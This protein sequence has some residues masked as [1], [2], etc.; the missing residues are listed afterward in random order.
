[1][2]AGPRCRVAY[3]ELMGRMEK[4]MAAVLVPEGRFVNFDKHTVYVGRNDGKE[5]F[6]ILVFSQGDTNAPEQ[7]VKAPRGRIEVVNDQIILHLYDMRAL[8]R[9][10]NGTW[11]VGMAE[12]CPEVL[13]APPKASENGKLPL[14]DMTFGQLRA[15]LRR[16]EDRFNE[17]NSSDRTPDELRKSMLAIQAEK[18]DLT[19]P[20][21]V[22]I[23]RQVAFSFACFGFTL[24]GIPLGIRA[25]R[26]E[27]NIGIAMALILVF[28]YYSFTII[29]QALQTHAEWAP[30]LIVWLPNII[31]QSVGAVMLWRA[32]RGT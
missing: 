12:D 7:V 5:L 22:Q 28:I 19:M 24:V 16:L 1:M 17:P 4:K 31:F 27:T 21:R 23:N 29:G 20:V 30:H 11:S 2:E 15:E 32:N 6:D 14:T 25:H 13:G 8:S 10:G 26:R 3:K 9:D 18:Q